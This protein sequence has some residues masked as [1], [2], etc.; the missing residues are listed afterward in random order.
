MNALGDPVMSHP[1]YEKKKVSHSIENFFLALDQL[2]LD[3]ANLIY[4]SA[5]DRESAREWATLLGAVL[6]THRRMEVWLMK[7]ARDGS[8]GPIGSVKTR[9]DLVSIFGDVRLLGA[10]TQ[11]HL[12]HIGKA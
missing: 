9:R 11:Y 6:V 4:D 10:L 3:V 8:L 5:P 7:H 1:A 12:D 2:S